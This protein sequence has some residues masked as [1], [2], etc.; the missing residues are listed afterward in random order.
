ME[1]LNRTLFKQSRE[2]EFFTEKELKMQIGHN[3]PFWYI[4]IVKELIDNSLDAC[5]VGDILPKIEVNINDDFFEI[6]D[7]G[8]GLNT[9]TIEKSLNYL[10]R[11]SDKQYYV[12]PTRGQMGNALK[13][14]W[15]APYVANGFGKVEIE[16][17]GLHHIIEVSLD[18][19]AQKPKI[20]HKREKSAVKNGT[21]IRIHWKNLPSETNDEISYF[22][23]APKV[24]EI[25]RD[26]AVFNPHAEFILNGF[27]YKPTL[28][29]WNKWKTDFPTSPH[30]Y[31]EYTLRDLIAAYVSHEKEENA[32]PKTVREF[33][34]EF[35]GLSSTRKQKKVIEGYSGTFLHDLIKDNDIDMDIVRNLLSLMKD[36]S[37]P[38]KPLQLGLIGEEHIKNRMLEMGIIEESFKYAYMKR[39]DENNLPY[40]LETA[41]AVKPEEDKSGR[42]IITGLNWTPTLDISINE[43]KECLSKCRVDFHDPIIVMIHLAKPRFE[44]VDRGKTRAA[45]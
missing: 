11:V 13:T 33:I 45:V 34:S 10:I 2:C 26:Y 43:I 25:I 23:K 18:L 21:T 20:E 24:D 22:Y 29:E 30:W 31:N 1:V 44:F 5:E 28:Q 17:M 39:Y 38:V 40:I 3:K 19:I 8:T 15:A 12:S 41:F 36:N 9:E 27:S 35:R 6:K 7:N 16:S 14:V 4:A 42:V 32:K 37:F